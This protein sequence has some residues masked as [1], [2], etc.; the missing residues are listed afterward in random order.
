MIAIHPNILEKDG[1]KEFV[2]LPYSEFLKIQE[3]LA[4]YEDLRILREAKQNEKDA[5]TISLE[6]MKKKLKV[7]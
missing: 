7:S 3:E 6:K 4:D 1:K 5:S 2:V